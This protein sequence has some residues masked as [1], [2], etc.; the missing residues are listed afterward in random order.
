MILALLVSEGLAEDRPEVFLIAT[1]S[2]SK[3]ADM[4]DKED[5]YKSV[6]WK[7]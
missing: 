3:Q 5:I 2:V 1:V 7:E 4:M 6:I